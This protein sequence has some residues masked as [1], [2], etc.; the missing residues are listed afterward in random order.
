MAESLGVATEQI[1]MKAGML[2]T[3]LFPIAGL[4]VLILALRYFKKREN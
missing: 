3:S 1:G 4:A 2:V